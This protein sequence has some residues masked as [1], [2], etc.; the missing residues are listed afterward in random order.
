MADT[1]GADHGTTASAV[2]NLLKKILMILGGSRQFME[3]LIDL[4]E[5]RQERFQ[6][7]VMQLFTLYLGMFS[8]LFLLVLGV[9]FILIDYSGAPRGVVFT[10]GG[11]LVFLVSVILIQITKK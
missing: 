6:R 8:G 1:K 2:S 5:N 11:L 7:R 10:V 4:L 3:Y 9:F